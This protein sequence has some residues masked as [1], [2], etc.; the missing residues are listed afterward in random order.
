[1]VYSPP[2]NTHTTT[3]QGS[4]ASSAAGANQFSTLV[5]LLQ[6]RAKEQPNDLAYQFLVDGK[7]EGVSSPTLS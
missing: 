4:A 3:T 2:K 6:Y 5:E 7:K 1:M